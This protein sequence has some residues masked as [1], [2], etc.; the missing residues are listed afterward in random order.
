MV[1]FHHGLVSDFLLEKGNYLQ[2][3][4]RFVCAKVVSAGGGAVAHRAAALFAPQLHLSG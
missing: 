3:S 1:E 2:T 4:L